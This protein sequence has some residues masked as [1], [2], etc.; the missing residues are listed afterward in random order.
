MKYDAVEIVRELFASWKRTARPTDMAS[1]ETEIRKFVKGRENQSQGKAIPSFMAHKQIENANVFFGT[2]YTERGKIYVGKPQ[3]VDGHVLVLGGA[4][5]GK[6]SCIVIPSMGT[7]G[8][9]FF[10]IDIKGELSRMKAFP[11]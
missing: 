6:S 3:D 1:G 7:W 8:G 5:S 10:A 2:R 9:T 4:G 11:N